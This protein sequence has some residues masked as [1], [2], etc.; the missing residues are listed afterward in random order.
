VTVTQPTASSYLTVWPTGTPRPGTSNINYLAGDTVP[1]V[2]IVPIGAA[3][4]VD[5]F[6]FAGDAHVIVDV[7]G[8]FEGGQLPYLG[9]RFVSIP[10]TRALDTRLG[11]GGTAHAMAANSNLFLD[12]RPAG[13]PASA[14]AVVMNVTVAGPTAGGYLTVWPAD[15]A[16]PDSS[17]LNFGAGQ[18][19][20]NLVVVPLG[21]GDRVSMYNAFG[22]TDVIADVVGYY[23]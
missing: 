3:G 11:T 1:N 4:S 19:T 22:N 18:V 2:V 13:V 10:P 16:M 23:R 14:T 8:V 9:G 7:L 12:V 5:F 17:N 15:G 20:A 6:N 21:S